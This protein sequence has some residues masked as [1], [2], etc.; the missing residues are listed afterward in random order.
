[1]KHKAAWIFQCPK[2]IERLG[3]KYAKNKSD[4]KQIEKAGR[5]H[6]AH[7]VGWREPDG[8]RKRQSCGTG[9][10]GRKT[11][12]RMKKKIEAQL[13]TGTYQP[14]E[15]INWDDFI[16]EIEESIFT[17][18][19]DEN[20]RIYKNALG[21]FKRLAKPKNVEQIGVKQIDKYISARSM[22]RGLNISSKTS[23][24]TIN[25]E[26]RHLKAIL[27]YAVEWGYLS[28]LPNFKRRW[29]REPEK[30]PTFITEEHFALIYQ[31]CE[32]AER[33]R[34]PNTPAPDWWRAL[35]TMAYMTGWRVDELISLKRNDLDLEKGTAVTRH[36]DNKGKRDAIVSLHEIVID[37]LRGIHGF[38]ENVFPWPQS[39]RMQ[40][41]EFH[42]IQKAAGI[43]LPCNEDHEHNET[44]HVYGFHDL[45]RAF[46]T[47][48]VDTL[49]QEELQRLMRHKSYA[50]TQ[51]YINMA[52]QL[53]NNVSGKLKVPGILKKK[54]S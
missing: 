9:E 26:L 34:L 10:D 39:R 12:F 45:R 8:S 41:H 23:P 5:K 21:H 33:P 32:V 13:I 47:E 14:D 28:K 53:R 7:C 46:A 4:E 35:I 2:E 48:N 20:V 25:K 50:T 49:S 29:L 37:H 18:M 11:A 17:T 22:E 38:D 40:W 16:Q 27:N 44:C 30:L 31:A 52:H 1:M 51:K 19:S 15:S 36:R 6:A 54:S 24:A 43:D 3:K 42:K